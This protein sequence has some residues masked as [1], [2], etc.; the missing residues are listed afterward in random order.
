MIKFHIKNPRQKQQL[1]RRK[2]KRQKMFKRANEVEI[3]SE[4]TKRSRRKGLPTR[5][6]QKLQKKT[7]EQ[8]KEVLED[9]VGDNDSNVGLRGPMKYIFQQILYK[10]KDLI[11]ETEGKKSFFGGLNKIF[12]ILLISR[13]STLSKI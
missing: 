4:K 5:P 2:N 11:S 6:K 12:T 3:S 13:R 10:F 8:I 7:I 1:T 9:H